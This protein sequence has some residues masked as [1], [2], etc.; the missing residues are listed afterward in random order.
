MYLNNIVGFDTTAAFVIPLLALLTSPPVMWYSK[1]TALRH[2]GAKG[3]EV[4]PLRILDLG[5]TWR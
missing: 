1:A 3:R 2:A 4:E 5:T